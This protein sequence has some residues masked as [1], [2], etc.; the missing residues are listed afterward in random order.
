MSLLGFLP[1]LP[2]LLRFRVSGLGLRVKGLEFRVLVPGHKT[3]IDTPSLS[4][5]ES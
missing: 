4:V 1:P 5:D 2:R 3:D